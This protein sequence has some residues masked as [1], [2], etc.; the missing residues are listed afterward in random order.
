MQAIGSLVGCE[1]NDLLTDPQV[2]HL[3][4]QEAFSGPL[5]RVTA[6]VRHTGFGP[7]TLARSDRRF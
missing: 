7:F 2:M 3:E 1:K 4:S 5:D 6:H